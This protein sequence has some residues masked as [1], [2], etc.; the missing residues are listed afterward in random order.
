MSST[1]CWPN[2]IAGDL[3]VQ[4]IAA[5]FYDRLPALKTEFRVQAE[6]TIA[7]CSHQKPD[8]CLPSVVGLLQHVKL[9]QCPMEPFWM[10]AFQER[11]PLPRQCNVPPTSVV[12][13]RSENHKPVSLQQTKIPAHRGPIHDHGV[14]QVVRTHT[15]VRSPIAAKTIY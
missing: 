12:L 5:Q 7:E 13:G 9:S 2:F 3:H 6:G 10:G 11:L 4:A 14:R 8:A 15:S 1:L